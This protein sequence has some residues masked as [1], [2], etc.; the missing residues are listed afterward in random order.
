MQPEDI[1]KLFRAKLE[2]HATP[3]PPSL[4]YDLQEQLEPEEQKR[5]GGFWMYAVAAAVALLLVA[6]GGWLVW[7]GRLGAPGAPAAG[8]LATTTTPASSGLGRGDESA[9][10]AETAPLST[11]AAD[12]GRESVSNKAAATAA[13]VAPAEPNPAAE[14]F[15]TSAARQATVNTRSAST[16]QPQQLLARTERAAAPRTS[17]GPEKPVFQP[18]DEPSVADLHQAVAAQPAPQPA[19]AA[20]LTP[21]APAGAPGGLPAGAIEVEVRQHPDQAVALAAADADQNAPGRTRPS[22]RG[23][24]RQMRRLAQGEKP[25]LAEVGLPAN[26]ALTVQARVAGHTLTKTISL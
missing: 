19:P 11:P 13:V 25:N 26:P 9:S 10:P 21:A 8:T 17:A 1:D 6:G 4:W 12:F 23:V 14:N 3:P 22:V 5:R 24:L 20:S 16:H 2:Q 18:A 15:A 7:Q